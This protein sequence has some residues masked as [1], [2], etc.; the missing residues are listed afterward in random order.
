MIFD[1]SRREENM[2]IQ[3]TWRTAKVMN[4]QDEV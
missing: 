2:V 3:K 4:K 1:R